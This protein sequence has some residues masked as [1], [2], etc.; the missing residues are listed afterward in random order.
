MR[1]MVMKTMNRKAPLTLSEEHNGLKTSRIS[2]ERFVFWCFLGVFLAMP[3][4]TSPPLILG[5]LGVCVWFFSGLALRVK[6]LLSLRWFWPVM[7]FITLPWIGLL[8]TPDP[9]GLGIN[10]AGKTYYWIFCLVLASLSLEKPQLTWIIKAFLLGLAVNACAGI[11]Q[12]AGIMAPKQGWFSGLTRGYISLGAYLPLGMLVCA[13]YFSHAEK[14]RHQAA[15]LGLLFLFFFHLILLAGRTG[16]FTFILVFP[17]LPKTLFKR[18][19]GWKIG[20]VCILIVGTMFFSPIVRQRMDLTFKQLLY[21]AQA[22]RSKAWGREYTEHQD[23]FYYWRGAIEIFLEHPILGVGTGGYA[24]TLK[25]M[26]PESDPLI[27]HPHNIFLYMAASFGVVGIVV[28][29]WLFLEILRNGWKG[30][31][32]EIGYFVLSTGLVLLLNG[33]FNTTILEAGTLLLLSL[34]AGLQQAIPEFSEAREGTY[35]VSAQGEGH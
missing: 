29:A 6:S 7:A 33:V 12:L 32:G 14:R 34:A 25:G 22:E 17:L 5:A 8:Y 28:L 27:S 15:S 13:F 4:G 3:I 31:D 2:A 18:L 30:R 19:S 16:Y 10:Y 26:R 11:F 20:A 1:E 23:R 24:V 35:H 21:H 9:G